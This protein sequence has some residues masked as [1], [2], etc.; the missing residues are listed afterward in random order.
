M[1]V[2]T[3]KY[4]V[5]GSGELLEHLTKLTKELGIAD[6]VHFHGAVRHG[7]TFKKLLQ[8]ADVFAHP[9]ITTKE[10]DK[11]GI[12]GAIVEAMASGLPVIATEHGGIPFV[13]TDLKT[14]FLI[15][16]YDFKE[17]A[18]IFCQ[19]YLEPS[20]RERIGRE[21]KEYASHHLDLIKNQKIC[22]GFTNPY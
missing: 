14:G 18:N 13:V 16:E 21:A 8:N 5:V 4:N 9:S 12:P 17:M 22:K 11:E 10:N 19:L 20:M 1:K 6:D 2:L 15:K 3:L 7:D